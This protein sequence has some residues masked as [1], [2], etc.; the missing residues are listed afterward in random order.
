MRRFGFQV[1]LLLVFIGLVTGCSGG[2]ANASSPDGAVVAPPSSTFEDGVPL[3]RLMERRVVNTSNYANK[4]SDVNL[5][6]EYVSPSGRKIQ[7]AGF[8]DGDGD[9]GQDGNVWKIRFMPDEPGTWSYTYTWSDGTSGGSGTFTATSAGGAPGVLRP[10]EDNTHWFAYNGKSPVFLKSYHVGAAG[11]TGTPIDWAAANVYEKLANRGYN[12]VMLKSLPIGWVNEK[13]SDA[14]ADHIARPIWSTTPRVQDLQV[15][16]RF[17]EHLRWLNGRDIHVHFFMGFDPK[18]DSV[19]DAFFAQTRFTDL[20]SDDQAL[21]VRYV[22]ARLAAFANVAGFNYTWETDGGA[23]E[24]RLMDLLAQFDPWKHL[25]TYH[26]ESPADNDYGNGRYSFAGIENHGYFG[27]A[28]GDPALDSASH[29]QATLDAYRDKPVY[30]VEGNGLW[31]ACWAKDN[32]ERTITRAAWAVTAAGGSFTWQDAPECFS[33]PV[34]GMLGWPSANPMANRLDV[35]YGVMTRDVEFPRMT[36]HND[37]LGGCW[38][39][40]N[41]YDAAP[42]SPC[43]LLAEP[44]KQYVAYK[45]DGGSFTLSLESGTY[46]ATWVDTRT[47]ARQPANGGSI[48]TGGSIVEFFTPDNS[49]DWVLVL[50]NS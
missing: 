49:T 25:T 23:G 4:F 28:N 19:P 27:N 46:R 22:S 44:G 6:V 35:L 15:W 13:P 45:E 31:R 48:S 41:R 11:F 7:F 8:Y 39:S 26:D 9:G 42:V 47:G 18:S 37:L 12:H 5:D 1:Y 32:A 40:F 20:S 30:M 33:G 43:F 24:Q 21:Y 50:K 2:G 17:E 36:P 16:K 38:G 29:Y 3:Y 14:P 10:Y 34:A